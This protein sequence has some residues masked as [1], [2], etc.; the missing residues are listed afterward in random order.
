MSKDSAV[1]IDAST[2]DYDTKPLGVHV[3]Q[4]TYSWTSP[5]AEDAIVMDFII[6]NRNDVPIRNLYCGYF[7]DNDIGFADINEP[8]GSNDD[9]IGFD[10]V[11]SLGYTYD[12]DG[13][14]EDWQTVAGYIGAVWLKGIARSPINNSYL[15]GFQTW[16]REGDES[17]TD[18][19]GF[20]ILRYKQL[21]NEQTTDPNNPY[22]VFETPQDVRMLLNTGPNRW[23]YPGESDTVTVAI[24]MGESLADLQ[25]NTRNIQQMYDEGYVL[26]EAPPSPNLTAYPADRKVFLSWDNFPET[27]TD[28]FT[29]KVDFEGYR[30]YKNLTGLATDWELLSEYD[31]YGTRSS[32]SVI[33]RITRGNTTARFYFKQFD[34]DTLRLRQFK[35]DQIYTIN[36][37]T[38]DNFVV[39]NQSSGVLYKYSKQALSPSGLPN[40]FCVAA[41]VGNRWTPLPF[42]GTIS[43]NDPNYNQPNL[44]FPP[45]PDPD[46]T[47]VYF[48]GMF[49]VLGTG[50]EDPAG[51]ATRDPQV[52]HVLEIQTFQGEVLGNETGLHYNFVDNNVRNGISYY[53]SVTSFDRGDP[54][55]ALPPLESSKKQNQMQ[56]VPVTPPITGNDPAIENVE[57]AGPPSGEATL[58]VAQPAALTG[59]H[60]RI[61]FFDS[62]QP[63]YGNA[64]YW[65]ITDLN[66]N[67]VLLDSMTNV[68]GTTYDPNAVTPL[69]DGIYL[70]YNV[71]RIPTYNSDL[72]GWITDNEDVFGVHTRDTM[73]PYDFELQFPNYP[74]TVSTD[75]N[76]VSVPFVAFNKILNENHDTQ[77]FDVDNDGVFSQG[78]SVGVFGKY[79]TGII[80][81]FTWLVESPEN[82]L[83]AGDIFLMNTDKPFQI[84]NTITF[85]ST[86]PQVA[87]ADVDLDQIKVVPNPY[88]IRADWDQ[89]KYTN[90]IMFTN[91]PERCTIRIFT[92]SGIL[93]KVIEH[94]GNS[95]DPD[96]MGGAHNWN[97]RNLEELKISSGL[98]IYQVESDAGEYVGKFVLVR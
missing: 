26:P 36:F 14:E 74:T 47:V 10:P 90:H 30:V 72:S 43:T 96:A 8:Q 91:L 9:L 98:Y 6:E 7:M 64:K 54:D 59:H 93:I 13:Y 52:G 50:P 33:T 70:D 41:R 53:Y 18:A 22:E 82:S 67:S 1:W 2:T 57:Y 48:D 34:Q 84:S 87:R 42:S 37:T 86:G 88:Y 94:D 58:E 78:D 17:N 21:N 97:L 79:E 25:E 95:G 20:D 38:E 85:R 80:F 69:V 15:T 4:R 61:S 49:F 35:G 77:L 16:T 71:N 66:T 62:L 60:Y 56:V 24:V 46:S 39:Y 19:L 75:V 73:E 65:R 11:L 5:I 51:L 92:L 76:G 12:F 45:N 44:T 55:L 81:T 31:I 63:P 28:P 29:G 68:Y 3:Y 89:N 32:N 23:L 27:V 40:S 83:E